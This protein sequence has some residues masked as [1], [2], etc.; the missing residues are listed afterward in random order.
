MRRALYRRPSPV[1][2][3]ETDGAEISTGQRIKRGAA[4]ARS[5]WG[6]PLYMGRA[7]HRRP[8]AL[9]LHTGV[10]VEADQGGPLP[11]PSTP[12]VGGPLPRPSL[13]AGVEADGPSTAPRTGRRA[14][15]RALRGC[16]PASYKAGDGRTLHR[17]ARRPGTGRRPAHYRVCAPVCGCGV[18]SINV[19]C[20]MM[21]NMMYFCWCW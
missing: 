12:C 17:T 10:R 8:S 15:G 13:S 2:C 18:R 9:R 14:P 4:S 6:G 7:L 5:G 20:G 16:A 3:V 21:I 11:R 19:M 1:E